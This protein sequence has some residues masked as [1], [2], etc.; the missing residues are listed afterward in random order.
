MTDQP[1]T[2]TPQPQGLPADARII[3]AIQN[4]CDQF[5][6]CGLM[7]PVV[8]VLAPGERKRLES[9]VVGSPLMLVHDALSEGTFVWGVQIREEAGG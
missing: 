9:A 6:I 8:I 5:A 4:L 7:A 1:K 3:G 2:T